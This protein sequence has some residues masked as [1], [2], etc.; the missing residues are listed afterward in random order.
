MTS[1]V[2]LWNLALINL[3]QTPSIASPTENST[4][5]NLCRNVYDHCRR[6]TLSRHDWNFARKRVTLAEIDDDREREDWE[7]QYGYPSDCVQARAIV[8]EARLDYP[9]PF[10]VTV[11]P[12]T[13]LSGSSDQQVIW[14][15]QADAVLEYTFD[16]SDESFFSDTYVQALAWC[17]ASFIAV[18]LTGK[19]AERDNAEQMFLYYLKIAKATNMNEGR[20]ERLQDQRNSFTDAHY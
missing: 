4:E 7:Y 11:L 15:N 14:T 19:K 9:I 10:K 6:Y 20:D 2:E 16:N 3:T 13:G 8:N 1:K 12:S 17:I 5:A 18:P